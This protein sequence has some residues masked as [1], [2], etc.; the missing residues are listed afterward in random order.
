M[1]GHLY[2][3][4]SGLKIEFRRHKNILFFVSI[5][6]VVGIGPAVDRTELEFIACNISENVFNVAD[7]VAFLA[8]IEEI[9][10]NL[11]LVRPQYNMLDLE[12]NITFC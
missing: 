6:Y 9:V 7:F 8:G 12:I 11:R 1:S 3:V 4:L 10:Q 5:T 2:S